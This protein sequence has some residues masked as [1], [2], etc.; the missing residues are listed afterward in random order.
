MIVLLAAVT[1]IGIAVLVYGLGPVLPIGSGRA[2]IDERITVFGVQGRWSAEEADERSFRERVL[3]P[4]LARLRLAIARRTPEARQ[5]QVEGR[6][7]LAGRPYGVTAPDFAIARIV[8]AVVGLAAGLGIGLL[9][10]GAGAMIVAAG[11]CALG[12]WLAPGLWLDREVS[13]RRDAVQAAMPDVLDLLVVAVDAGL[14][15]DAGLS[16]VIE[17]LH[18]PLTAELELAQREISLGQ[19]RPNALQRMA[20]RLQTDDVQRF[21]NALM[22]ADQLGIPIARTLR[23][24]AEE[25]RVLSRQRIAQRAARAPVRMVIPMIIFILPTIWLILLG[26]ALV[27]IME[28]GL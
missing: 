22:Q 17:K 3:E 15:F 27:A 20:D 11:L 2:P 6:L 23:S 26:P 10:G 25:A 1:G 12:A 19:P 18:N 8:L 13:R 7:E 4:P 24:Q 16:R 9:A 5:R 14:S 28:H 21:V